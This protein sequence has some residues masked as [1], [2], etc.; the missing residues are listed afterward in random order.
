MSEKLKNTR[1]ILILQGIPAS[2]KTYFA[3]KWVNEDPEHR[4]RFNNDDIRH[5]LGKYWVPSREKIVERLKVGF[6]SNA[7][8]SGYDIVVDNMNLN[9]REL[10]YIENLV[11]EWNK[12]HDISKYKTE[13]KQFFN[14]SL[15]TCIERDSKRDNKIGADVITGIYKRYREYMAKEHAKENALLSNT[16]NQQ[17]LQEVILVD[18]DNT[19]TYNLSGRKWWGEPE[20]VLLDTPNFPMISLLKGREDIIIVTGRE[21]TDDMVKYSKE[22]LHEQGIKPIKYYGRSIGDY[23]PGPD[24][25]RDIYKQYIECSYYTKAVFED[26]SACVEMWRDLGL[27]CLQNNNNNI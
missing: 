11:L 26:N 24:V 19:L 17:D 13:Y 1:T 7:M 23:R 22:W 9:L 2:G 16:F 4:I 3:K 20:K 5:M 14:V 10:E 21:M 6:F 15:K 8:F 18:M 25:K 12:D 27:M